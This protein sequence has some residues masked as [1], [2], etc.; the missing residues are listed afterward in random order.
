M[1]LVA[2]QKVLGHR[3]IQTT[4]GYVRLSDEMAME[5]GKGRKTVAEAVGVDDTTTVTP[6]ALVAQ[7]DRATVS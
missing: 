7:A 5:E 6:Y 1:S 2:V 4:Q 3:D